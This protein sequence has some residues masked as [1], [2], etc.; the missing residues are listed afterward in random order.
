MISFSVCQK[1]NAPFYTYVDWSQLCPWLLWMSIL[2]A[3]DIYD[4]HLVLTK[5]TTTEAVN[6]WR[7]IDRDIFNAVTYIIRETGVLETVS[8]QWTHLAERRTASGST[9]FS[10]HYY[11]SAC[12][13]Y[14][15]L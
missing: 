14:L 8:S 11:F 15:F 6:D 4:K 7:E 9:V 5:M 13:F 1:K 3:I 2:F 10:I 12:Y